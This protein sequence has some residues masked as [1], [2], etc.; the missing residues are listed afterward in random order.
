M[1]GRRHQIC[2]NRGRPVS[3]YTALLLPCSSPSSPSPPLGPSTNH[4]TARP[5]NRWTPPPAPTHPHLV[6]SPPLGVAAQSPGPGQATRA[7]PAWATGLGA[8]RP[9]AAGPQRGGL[10]VL[11]LYPVG[12]PAERRRQRGAA[13]GGVTCDGADVMPVGAAHPVSGGVH[14]RVRVVGCWD[15]HKARRGGVR[16]YTGVSAGV[17]PGP[18]PGLGPAGAETVVSLQRLTAARSWHRRS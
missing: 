2:C 11:P 3:S 1:S 14:V 17:G 4:T 6:L 10:L 12:A 16:C 18:G 7:W 9:S 8:L 15:I 5:P 13:G